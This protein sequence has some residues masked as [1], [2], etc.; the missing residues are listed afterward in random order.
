MGVA[1]HHN[2]NVRKEN[3]LAA[4]NIINPTL[5]INYEGRAQEARKG[6]KDSKQIKLNE[7]MGKDTVSRTKPRRDETL[8]VSKPSKDIEGPHPAPIA[9]KKK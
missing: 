3:V 7:L 1:S 2:S 5:A 9:P 8:K 4:L 6:K